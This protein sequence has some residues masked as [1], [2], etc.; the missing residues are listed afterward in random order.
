MDTLFSRYRNLTILAAVLFAQVVILGY[1]VRVP[2]ERG[3]VR[4]TRVWV[5]ALFTPLEK[6]IV[7]TQ[8]GVTNTWQ[9][10]VWLRSVRR[11]ND[12]LRDE[13]E[14][15]R[16]E[17][18]RL[19]QDAAQAR[20]L[21]VLLQFKE[22]TVSETVAA[23]I[24]GASGTET[25]RTITIDKGVDDGVKAD[26][27]VI[28]PEGVVGKVL[29]V[30]NEPT[31]RHTAQ[32]L[33]LTDP[34]SGVGAILEKSRLQGIVR[35]TQAGELLL[36]YVMSD[37]KVESGERVLTSG[38]DRVFPKGMQLGTVT[39]VSPG[40]ELFLNIRV[41]PAAQLTRLEEVLVITKVVDSVPAVGEASTGPVRA[42]DVLAQ[43]LPTIVARPPDA[44]ASKNETN[45]PL[46][47]A[48]WI[49]RQKQAQ[50]Q[51]AK[52][53]NVP[54]GTQQFVAPKN[55][56][57]VPAPPATA[58]TNL[59][60][61]RTGGP[62]PSAGSASPK[63][64]TSSPKQPS[65]TGQNGNAQTSNP[66]ASTTNAAPKKQL[67]TTQTNPSALP[68]GTAPAA[69]EKS[70]PKQQPDTSAPPKPADQPPATPPGVTL[71]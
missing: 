53:G 69:P 65:T 20:R 16:L 43:R 49:R 4:L 40:P 10:Y 19:A 58:T 30:Y 51:A 33:L 24:I 64:V 48:E 12:V 71:R 27:A 55:P 39:Q 15:L 66:S 38:G 3:A 17:Q 45:I 36:Q 50:Q 42:A 37:E 13:N 68:S 34:S 35:G 54:P 32:V 29:R 70:A 1:Q 44:E 61:P 2:H 5:M 62:P 14:K 63:P 23:Q 18:I 60:G 56:N 67:S 46:S 47:M 21:Q 11:E 7:H 6:A 22:Q 28:A 59:A 52:Q 31:M 57:G 26:A 25:S 41:K 8:Q 9:D